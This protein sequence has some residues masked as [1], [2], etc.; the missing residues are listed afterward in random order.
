VWQSPPF[1]VFA[2]HIIARAGEFARQYNDALAAYRTQK[3]VRTPTRPMPDLAALDASAEI[4]FWLDNL[5]AG[6][7]TRPTAVACPGGR[8][9]FVLKT[10]GGDEFTFNPAANGWDAADRLSR[11]LREHRL[12]LSPRALTLTM[13][14]RLFMVDQFVHGIGGGQYDQVTD[15]IIASHFRLAPPRFA[16]AT[17]TMYLPEAV[18]RSRVCV[19]CI[20]QEG[21]RLKHSVLGS[22][23]AELL[24]QINAAPRRSQQRYATFAAMHRELV[25]A[26]TNHPAFA[27]WQ[28]KLAEAQ[29]REVAESAIF[30]RELFYAIQPRHRLQDMVRRIEYH[31]PPQ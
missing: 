3:K 15:R 24:D 30:D 4:P 1:L 2:H 20:E 29:S 17:G 27:I 25:T 9:G 14:L 8:G 28:S 7:R 11:W 12:R 19:A 23:K 21:H 31:F 13:F 26:A 22:R 6:E 10:P 5:S 16:V 18:G